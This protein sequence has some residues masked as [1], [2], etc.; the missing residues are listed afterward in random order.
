VKRSSSAALLN[1]PTRIIIMP[2]IDDYINAK[3]IAVEALSRVPFETIS[4]QTGFASPTENTFRIPFLDRIYLVDY[5]RFEFKDSATP[6]KEIPLQEQVLILHYMLAGEM[7]PPARHWISYREIPGA[8]FYFGAF[9]KRAVEP[10]KKVFGINI[11]GFSK[12]ARKL[13]GAEIDNGDAGF[14]FRVLPGVSLQ[15]IIWSGDDEFPPEANILFDND[16][17][18]ILSPEDVAWL[19]GMVVYRLIGLAR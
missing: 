1:P 19:A 2:R 8:A 6:D 10:L 18:Q 17:G 16:I 13:N 5:P 12:A 3:K 14:E 9:V 7:P 4:K 15:L 11:A